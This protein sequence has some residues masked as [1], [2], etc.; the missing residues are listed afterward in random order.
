MG[1]IEFGTDGWRARLDEFTVPRV[2][3]VGRAV[4]EY[5]DDE[6]IGGDVIVGYDAREGSRRF[7]EELAD[8]LTA[9]GRDVLLPDR[10]F[11]TPVIAWNVVDRG[12]A[13]AIAVTASHNP[14]EYNGVK[15]VPAD[16]A[17]P[18]PDV[19]DRIER[20]LGSPPPDP[21]TPTGDVLDV[22][23]FEPY[24]EHALAL[25]DPPALDDLTVAYD[26]MHA[27][28]R[29]VTDALLE[30]AGAT[31]ERI[32]C[33][34][35]PDFGGGAPEPSAER[36]ER[37]HAAVARGADLGIANDGDAD[38]IAVVTPDRGYIGGDRLYAVL[39]DHLL[40]SDSGPAVRTVSTTF[41]IDRI[42][43]AHG[44]ETDETPVGFKW[45]ADAMATNDALV[46]GE[47]SDGLTVRGHIRGKDGVLMALYAAGA[48]VEQSL[49]ARLDAIEAEYGTIAKDKTSV[50]CPDDAKARVLEELEAELPEEIGGV[51]VEDVN[52]TDGF[53]ILLENGSWL[54]VRPSGTEPKMRIY[55]E[56]DD[57]ENVRALLDVG[58][59]L[60]APLV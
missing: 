15:F 26:A 7:A 1:A 34:R 53:K 3:R 14:P 49:D 56:A 37:L 39:Y 12:L 17:P 47:E 27:S 29:D 4:V 59:D 48:D 45:I 28:G 51:A 11:P 42:A 55:A 8:V 13:G 60:V 9:S 33:D 22:E 2:R 46:G 20:R 6:G 35:D 54:L 36:L 32:R 19:M 24:V 58:Q 10:D 50:A 40:E 57:R 21:E 31:V 52:T 18:L 44:E 16:G 25:A 5:L 38:R 41:L 30:R 43:A 23:P